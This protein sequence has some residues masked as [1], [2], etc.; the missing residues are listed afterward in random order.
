M[1]VSGKVSANAVATEENSQKNILY[2]IIA[3]GIVL[4]GAGFW[5]YL[6]GRDENEYDDDE[7]DDEDA[8]AGY[9]DAD[10]L[11]DA[12]IALDDAYRAGDLIETVYKKRRAELKRKLQE[13]L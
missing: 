8:D 2:G 9:D 12:I 10:K 1:S 5:Y 13:L 3:L 6:R 7:D 11:M 4:I